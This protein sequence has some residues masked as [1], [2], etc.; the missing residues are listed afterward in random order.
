MDSNVQIE[1]GIVVVVIAKSLKKAETDLDLKNKRN[2]DHSCEERNST[3]WTF[4][5]NRLCNI[6]PHFLEYDDLVPFWYRI[7][8]RGSEV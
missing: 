7:D 2:M 5:R 4:W 8:V 1:I 3:F 6:A